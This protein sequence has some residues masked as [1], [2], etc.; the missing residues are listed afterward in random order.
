MLGL[1]GKTGLR[2]C[3]RP[4][5]VGFNGKFK[6]SR[7][8]NKTKTKNYKPEIKS[9]IRPRRESTAGHYITYGWICQAL[10]F[11]QIAQK[12]SVLDMRTLS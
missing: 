8:N 7:D 6:H 4:G 11:R 9:K 10:F 5:F 12:K 3:A 2:T 1:R